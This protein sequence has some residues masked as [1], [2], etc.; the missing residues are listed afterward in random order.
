MREYVD[1]ANGKDLSMPSLSD[2]YPTCSE[3]SS[4][5]Q[6]V[7]ARIKLKGDYQGVD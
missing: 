3:T 2:F 7:S 4:R 6:K 1:K 5:S